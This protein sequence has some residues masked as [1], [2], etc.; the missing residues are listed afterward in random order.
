MLLS[1]LLPLL[2]FVQTPEPLAHYRWKNRLLVV[3]AS[4]AADKQLQA[5][6]EHVAANEA[7]FHDRD[8]LQFTVLPNQVQGPEQHSAA[9]A[10][11]LRQHYKVAKGEFVVLLIGKDGTVKLRKNEPVSMQEIFKLIDTM[12]MR[13]AEMRKGN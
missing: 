8:L 3:F 5:Q 2:M 10:K 4:E 6:S 12:P 7:G 9:V 11:Q 13:K 1:L